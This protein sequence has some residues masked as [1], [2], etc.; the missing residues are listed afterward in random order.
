MCKFIVR[1]LHLVLVAAIAAPAFAGHMPNCCAEMTL[2]SA[3]HARGPQLPA[4][5]ACHSEAA[6]GADNT[7]PPDSGPP[8]RDTC[9]Y[10]RCD[11]AC[12]LA[13]VFVGLPAEGF[14]CAFVDGQT[15]SIG[16]TRPHVDLHLPP[17]IRP[18]IGA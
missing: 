5:T 15:V 14:A 10:H 7:A 9:R 8:G 1:L 18:P 17:D 2:A 12:Q 6:Q 13:P 4:P 16:P 11:G 3:G